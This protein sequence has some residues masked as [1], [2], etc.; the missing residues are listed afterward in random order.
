MI[1]ATIESLCAPELGFCKSG[2]AILAGDIRGNTDPIGWT[3]K[4]SRPL[5]YVFCVGCSL[6]CDCDSAVRIVLDRKCGGSNRCE[7]NS[8]WVAVGIDPVH[9]VKF[10]TDAIDGAGSARN[11]V[12]HGMRVKE[13]NTKVK[14]LPVGHEG[15][16]VV[17]PD[18]NTRIFSQQY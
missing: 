14:T 17:I 4:I 18:L 10:E 1:D 9:I 11:D 5:E 6:H 2:G 8:H 13:W 7:A 12:P 3:Q 16:A 15:G